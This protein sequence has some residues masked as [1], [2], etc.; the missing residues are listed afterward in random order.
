MQCPAVTAK[1]LVS[2]SQQ[3][4]LINDQLKEDYK[5]AKHLTT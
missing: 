5:E 4:D 2:S 3:G 1:P